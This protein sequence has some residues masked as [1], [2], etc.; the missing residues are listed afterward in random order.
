M[1]RQ[2]TKSGTVN[3]LTKLHLLIQKEAKVDD[4]FK[5]KKNIF[6]LSYCT[7]V[8]KLDKIRHGEK[9]HSMVYG[10]HYLRMDDTFL[11]EHFSLKIS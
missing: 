6:W 10:N 4:W 9:E 7:G 2:V 5:I 3:Q 11:C 8:H 1:I